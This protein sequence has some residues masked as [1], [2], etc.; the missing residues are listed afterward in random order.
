[1]NKNN[2]L[3]IDINKNFWLLERYIKSWQ[4]EKGYLNGIIATFWDWTNKTIVPHTMNH[5]PV[6]LG[7]LNL[8]K[9]F[10]NQVYLREAKKLAAFYLDHQTD[11]GEF[12][13]AWADIPPK[14]TGPILQICPDLALVELYKITKDNLYL[15]AVQKN[16][17]WLFNNWWDKN[18]FVG[19]VVNQNCKGIELFLGLYQLTDHLKYKHVA[20]K[21]GLW[22]LTQQ[23]KK[24]DIGRGAFYQSIHDDRL[25]LVY[26]AKI[27]PALL[28]L[29]KFTGN[30]LYKE[31]IKEVVNFILKNRHYQGLFNSHLEPKNNIY[32][33]FMPVYKLA[34]FCL[35]LREL[36]RKYKRAIIKYKIYF[37]PMWIARSADIIRSLLL[38]ADE[39]E[40]E[41]SW[42]ENLVKTLLGFQYTNG[43][44]PNTL[45]YFGDAKIT[46]WQDII[47]STRWNA[48]VFLLLSDFVDR[49]N[50]PLEP[51]EKIEKMYSEKGM[52][53]CF[54]E[55]ED[56]V[57]WK[58]DNKVIQRFYKKRE[59][60]E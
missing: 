28:S 4:T 10:N 5:Y 33:S 19:G 8:Y 36:V 6:I 1:M 42:L 12:L 59:N 23:R 43:G 41:K 56:I 60:H 30:P 39:C 15:E 26:N 21:L 57:E 9:K 22:V 53:Y 27:I 55:T 14:H 40:I 16:I 47:A 17:E 58:K 25:I 3:N 38:A 50:Y 31:S 35:P 45:G 49:E 13:N 11:K 29:Y 46:R 54:I 18:K 37:Y 44:F 32:R 20:E 51:F 2:I 52:E 7:Y 48:Y 24:E 34:K